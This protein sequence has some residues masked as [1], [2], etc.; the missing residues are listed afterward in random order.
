MELGDFEDLNLII[1][2][3]LIF[4]LVSV[5]FIAI[6]YPIE[7]ESC[8]QKAEGLG[9]DYHYGLLTHCQYLIDGKYIPQ[10]NYRYEGNNDG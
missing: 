1:I 3:I 7:K 8:K 10:E 5:L 9:V 2:V 4:L 6:T